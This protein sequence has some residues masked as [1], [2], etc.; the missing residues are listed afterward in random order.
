MEMLEI[1][2]GGV[3]AGLNVRLNMNLFSCSLVISA[4]RLLLSTFE[5]VK[6]FLLSIQLINVIW[7]SR[8]LYV[9]SRA[10]Y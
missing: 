2:G 7:K 10:T 8:H 5:L 1:A 4:F 6:H 3:E 9:L